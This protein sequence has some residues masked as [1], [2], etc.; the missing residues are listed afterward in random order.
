[1]TSSLPTKISCAYCGA[2][3]F[4]LVILINGDTS[5]R[6]VNHEDHVKEMDLAGQ[7]RAQQEEIEQEVARREAG[8]KAERE[9][10]RRERGEPS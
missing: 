1:M 7:R 10:Q 8:R 3:A 9:R 2:N 5:I 6:C 4:T